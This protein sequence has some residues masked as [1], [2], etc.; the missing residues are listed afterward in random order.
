MYLAPLNYDRYFRKVFSDKRIAKRFLEDFFDVQIQEIELL[1]TYHKITDNATAIEFDFRCKIAGSF[2]I[3]DMQQW[4]KTDIVKRFYMYHSMNTVLQL[5]KIPD[6]TIDLDKQRKRDIKDYDK[7][8]PVITLIWMVDDTFGFTDD[9]VSYTMAPEVIIDFIRNKNL[10]R[11]EN[12]LEILSER[13]K[14]LKMLDN[15]TRKLNYLQQNR[16]I[17]A[18]QKN[19]VKNEKY[20]KYLSWFQLAEKTLNKLNKKGW[21][22]KYLK[23]EIFAEIVRRISKENLKEEDYTYI[24]DYNLFWEQVKRFEDALLNEGREEG[25]EEGI[26]IGVKIQEEKQHLSKD[27]IKNI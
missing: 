26:E 4:Y 12:I 17:Y 2:V 23:D 9:F 3:I 24:K 13:E 20:S 6:K 18:F 15:K 27:E 22:D 14:Y 10:W 8:I 7:L 1:Q 25:R 5:E 21:F 19:I 16:L 11:S